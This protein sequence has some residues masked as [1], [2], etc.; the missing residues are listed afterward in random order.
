[1]DLE[2]GLS[3]YQS[4]ANTS[5]N[6]RQDRA[7][8]QVLDDGRV[9]IDLR[10]IS[11]KA[12]AQV[13]RK[14]PDYKLSETLQ[15]PHPYSPAAQ[16][17]IPLNII[18]QVVGSR[19][20]VQPF[21][22]LG[23]ELQKHGHR[24]RLATHNVF[25]EF[26]MESGLEF[27]PIGGNP[28]DLMAYMVKN[29][30]LIPSM[31]SIRAGEV[32][33]KRKMIAEVLDGCWL[34]CIEPDPDSGQPFVA[35]AVIANPPSFAHIHCAQAL[36][37]PLHLMFT[38][39]WT[40]TTAFPH[41]L[42]NITADRLGISQ[43]QLNFLSYGIVEWMTWQGQPFWGEMVARAGAGPRPIHHKLINATNLADAITFCLQQ[44]T[45]SAAQQLATKI[46]GEVGVTA[47]VDSFH[48]HFPFERASC[49]LLQNQAAAWTY[50][51]VVDIVR[52]P[53][54]AY[55]TEPVRSGSDR[56]GDGHLVTVSDPALQPQTYKHSRTCLGSSR[57]VMTSAASA[58]GDFL[59]SGARSYYVNVPLAITEGLRAVPKLY[60]EP[61]PDH[62]PITG[63]KSGTRVAGYQFALGLSTGVCDIFV[64]PYLG[65]RNEGVV[66]AVKG[67]A[68]GCVGTVT[69]IGSGTKLF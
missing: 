41:P 30:G 58:I 12:L 21:V 46:R 60:G 19:G 40:S 66:G 10:G 59:V 25:K 61:V 14:T 57:V 33:K 56:Q 68:K 50:K 27:Y 31:D 36:G 23:R 67:L 53:V 62:E 15:A 65:A 3:Q 34:S 13:I 16:T 39:P 17:I 8:L 45:R 48:R 4:S 43:D 44:E 24:V 29:P 54:K 5:S 35:N 20:D 32:Q 63:W 42:A 38:M 55:K 7:S 28:A 52:K 64:Q 9:D 18:I 47:A 37:I 49:D 26:I 11:S 2:Q 51:R 6:L 69:K 1:M 22:A